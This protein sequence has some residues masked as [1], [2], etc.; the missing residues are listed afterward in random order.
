MSDDLASAIDILPRDEFNETLVAHVHPPD[1]KSP[2]PQGKYNLVAIGGGTAGLISAIGAAGLGGKAAIVER[3]LLGGDCLNFGCVPSKALIRAA[4]VAHTVASAAE[5]GVHA[6]RDGGV[7]FGEVMARMRRLRAEIGRHD[8]ARRFTDAGVDVF[9]GQAKFIGPDRLEVDGQPLQFARAVVCTGARAAKLPI[10]GFDDVGY[11]TN[12]TLFSLTELP[13]SLIVIGG[14]P[15][16]SE[17]GQAFRRF[18]A[19]VHVIDMADRIMPRAEPEASAIVQAQFEKD[20]IHL[21][22]NAKIVRAEKIEGGKRVVIQQDG[23]QVVVVGEEILVAVGRAPNVERLDLEAA[24][25]E[26]AQRGVKVNDF[27][28]T[29]NPRIYAAGDVAGSYQFTHAADAMARLCLRN[30][31]FFGRGRLSKLVVPNCTYTD[32]EVAQIGLTPAEAARRNIKIDSYRQD[33]ASVDRA[34]LDG[35]EEGFA[36]IHTK[37]GKAEIVGATIVASHAG[38]MIGEISLMMTKRMPISALA[39]TIHCYPTQVEALKRIGD[40]YNKTRLTPFVARM[41]KRL[42]AWRRK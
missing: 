13:R 18:G 24:G 22:L 40:A 27:L 20:G 15:I 9:F 8:A 33:F 7:M 29:T 30:A 14:G 11:L 23:R 31:L 28:Q 19:E 32:P 41:F 36:V 12:E 10:D 17:M 25:V 39:E 26:M 5:Y 16:G 6:R 2:T 35:E 1:W 34:I 21:H 4:R 3:H 42:L 37:K 38:E